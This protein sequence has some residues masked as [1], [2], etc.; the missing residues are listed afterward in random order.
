MAQLNNARV[1]LKH[2]GNPPHA[3]QMNHFIVYTQ[4][5][6]DQATPIVF[7]VPLD[8]VS[9]LSMI[10]YELA[11]CELTRAEEEAAAGKIED[12]MRSCALAF[13]SLLNEYESGGLTRDRGGSAFR[14]PHIESSL[15]RIDPLDPH[16]R[17]CISD[18]SWSV[19]RIRN[20]LRLL[21]FG[22][23]YRRY[24][25]FRQLAPGIVRL[26]NGKVQSFANVPAPTANDLRF[27]IDFVIDTALH[28]QEFRLW[29]K[30][31]AV[32]RPEPGKE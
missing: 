13:D 25:I 32:K 10:Q 11:R 21:C 2:Y 20:E 28:L 15:S 7:G 9:M 29:D 22:V 3:D 24:A 14:L 27:C 5:F 17:S 19:N 8:S 30:S 26:A 23:D 4:D 1:G 16:L 31:P 6:L 18:L 12:G